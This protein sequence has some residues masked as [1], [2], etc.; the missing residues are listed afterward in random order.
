M[1]NILLKSYGNYDLRSAY[2]IFPI[3]MGGCPLTSDMY[4]DSSATE[5]I[6]L[7]ER[8]STV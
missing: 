4:D 5:T 8:N 3:R 2:G 6:Q 7:Q 1:K